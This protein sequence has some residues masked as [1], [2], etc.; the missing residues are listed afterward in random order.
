M[1]GDDELK[2]PN[3]DAAAQKQFLV[4][5]AAHFDADIVTTKQVN[6]FIKLKNLP[7]PHFL[8][9]MASAKAGWGKYRVR[10]SMTDVSA[11]VTE[12]STAIAAMVASVTPIKGSRIATNATESFYPE[13]DETYV[14][15][16]FYNDL[17]KIISSKIFYPVYITGLSGNG[18][19]VM[20][21]Q[22]CAAIKREMRPIS[23]ALMS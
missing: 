10:K 6:E 14:P 20:V 17:K 5:I 22:I 23:L 15:F 8:F 3:Y 16:G 9:A 19:T 7:Y 18:K 4:D 21:E 11:P 2:K 1:S 13:K 12:Q